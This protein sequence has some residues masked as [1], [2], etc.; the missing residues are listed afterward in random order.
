[1]LGGEGEFIK[2]ASLESSCREEWVIEAEGIE[3]PQSCQLQRA[4]WFIPYK[5]VVRCPNVFAITCDENLRLYAINFVPESR[6]SG[7]SDREKRRRNT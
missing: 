3:I 4:S 7:K 6:I 5:G 1:V 2:F